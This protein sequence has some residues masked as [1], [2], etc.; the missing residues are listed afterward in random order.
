M[1][2]SHAIPADIKNFQQAEHEHSFDY[3]NWRLKICIWQ[4]YFSSWSPK[5]DLTIFLI[6]SPG[7]SQV[8]IETGGDQKMF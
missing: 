5:G 7:E 6:S 3:T 8:W 4:L 1:S 2:A